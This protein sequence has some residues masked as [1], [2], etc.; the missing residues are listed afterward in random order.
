MCE[1]RGVPPH[2][3]SPAIAALVAQGRHEEAAVRARIEGKHARAAELFAT[4]WK[5]TEAIA[6]ARE[7]GE[8]A[9]AYRHAL[10]SRD[11][12]L[13]ATALDEV[14]RSPTE[15]Q[16][17][18]RIA[19][20]RHRTL[21]AAILRHATGELAEAARLFT[22]AGESV[23]AAECHEALGETRA[24]GMLYEQRLREAPEDARAAL[25][26]GRIL[27]GMG[28]FEPATNALQLLLR[29]PD[30]TPDDLR[31]ARR[32]LVACFA[33]L[34][35]SE[36]AGAVLDQLRRE[37]P[38]LPASVPDMLRDTFG[39]ARG[40]VSDAQ[41]ELIVGRYR[42]KATL[43]EG[44]AG[45]VLSAEDTFYGRAVALKALRATGGAA[46]RDALARFAREAR[47]AMGIDHPNVVRVLAYHPEGPYLVM[48]L[49][50]GGTLAERLGTTDAPI[51]PLVPSAAIAIA[52]SIARGLDAVHR[53]G[54]VHRDLKPG[55]VLFSSAGEPKISDFGVAHLVD[56]GA[57]MTGAMMGTLETMAP[58]QITG[59]VKPDA[60]TDL[61]AL[62]MILHRALTGRLPFEGSDL[63]LAH[64]D[65]TPGAASAHASWLDA[66][67]DALLARML[68]KSQADRPSGASEVLLALEA[69]PVRRYDDAFA[70]RA[71]VEIARPATGKTSVPP[72]SGPHTTRYLDLAMHPDRTLAR[73]ELL[74]R[75]VELR[76]LDD[77][78][79]AHAGAW[80][81]L[82]SPYLQLV[83]ALEDSTLVLEHDGATTG[84]PDPAHLAHALET[85][86]A[87]GLVH[88]S[89]DAAHV[90]VAPRRTTLRLPTRLS[91]DPTASAEADLRALARLVTR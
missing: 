89:V 4:V 58:E 33:A 17:A 28:R 10:T 65:E 13:I 6:S 47:V 55:N 11:R 72:P 48:E 36:A 68:E 63:A 64:V 73:D 7:S 8:L 71:P 61:Y 30:A 12:E 79:R 77:D 20:D 78:E 69:L 87:A 40:L 9:E 27:V 74:G 1:H 22:E 76:S 91:P 26:L 46:G 86:H 23:R 52:K 38:A 70:T 3:D 84:A 15:A 42:V 83:A 24:A 85:I 66:A 82:R 32:L 49:M 80:A 50:E 5:Y 18:A 88:G 53:R 56:L 62:G 31:A 57:T 35:L 2:D 29:S 90:L 21:D 75:L 41:R 51:G 45:R 44:S 54:V 67:I 60:T 37:D 34:G 16:K 39:D 59:N 25:A 14:T 19:E 81:K 43:G